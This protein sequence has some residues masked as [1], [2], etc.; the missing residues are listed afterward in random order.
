MKRQLLATHFP[1][2]VL[3]FGILVLNES[4]SLFTWA[5][6]SGSPLPNSSVN[7]RDRRQLQ[8]VCW[9]MNLA[10]GLGLGFWGVQHTVSSCILVFVNLPNRGN[11]LQAVVWFFFLF[12]FFF[13]SPLLWYRSE[14]VRLENL[15]ITDWCKYV[16]GCDITILSPCNRFNK[17]CSEELKFRVPFCIHAHASYKPQESLGFSTMCFL[18]LKTSFKKVIARVKSLTLL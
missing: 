5:H 8:L 6:S 12:F 17:D 4:K 10:A 14:A 2:G 7:S 13:P 15:D 11:C 18:A 3:D 16:G 9:E 1:W